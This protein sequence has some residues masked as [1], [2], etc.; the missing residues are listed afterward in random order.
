MKNDPIVA[1]VRK[2]RQKY[3]SQFEYDLKAMFE[4][5]CR[6]TEQSKEAGRRVA[7]PPSRRTHAGLHPARRLAE[8]GLG[9]CLYRPFITRDVHPP[10]LAAKIR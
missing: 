9:D 6:K 10:N 5:L 1:E 4:D 8:G 7:A 2:L 3:F